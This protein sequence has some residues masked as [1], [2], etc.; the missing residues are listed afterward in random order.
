MADWAARLKTAD[1]TDYV[2]LVASVRADWARQHR[3]TNTELDWD[4]QRADKPKGKRDWVQTINSLGLD[5]QAFEDAEAGGGSNGTAA[6]VAA[7]VSDVERVGRHLQTGIIGTKYLL[8]QL[9]LHG[10]AD[11]AWQ[12]AATPDFPG[13]GYMIVSLQ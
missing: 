3:A 12:V 10:R 6:A 2:G 1:A 8:R 11:L 7:V 13:W 5:M 9:S 4:L